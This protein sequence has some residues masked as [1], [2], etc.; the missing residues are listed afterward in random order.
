M[1]PA[2]PMNPTV[3][4]ETLPAFDPDSNAEISFSIFP[5][6]TPCDP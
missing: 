2:N 1:N 6:E 5:P 3:S 4:P